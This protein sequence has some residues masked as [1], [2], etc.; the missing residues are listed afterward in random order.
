MSHP[1]GVLLITSD[2]DA[3]DGVRAVLASGDR[4]ELA[5]VCQALSE[6]EDHFQRSP[7]AAVLVDIDPD[8]N[9]VLARLAAL[10][11]RFPDTRFIVL[12]DTLRSDVLMEAMQAGARHFLV[13]ASIGAELAGAL[14]RLVPRG[15]AGPVGHGTIITVLSASGGCGATT[16][17]VNLANELGL[18]TSTTAL[19]VDLDVC[20]GA[21]A[22]YL[23]LRGQF[24]I[25]DVF[26]YDGHIDAH[27]IQTTSV[28]YS[29]TL[30][31]LL[32]P[33]AVS[34]S[35]P[36]PLRLEALADG[37]EAC[38][39]AFQ[40]TVIDAPRV[41][42]DV[43]AELARASKLT[44]IVFELIVT[45]IHLARSCTAALV[46]RGIPRERILPVANRYARR[47]PV[48]IKEAREAL[49]DTEVALVRG[50]FRSAVQSINYGQPLAQIVPR[51][52]V[53][54]DIRALAT[55]VVLKDEVA[56]GTRRE[57]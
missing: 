52:V 34:F 43:A 26:A 57:R 1:D 17:A 41:P 5:G 3:I 20:Y 4:F 36:K 31:V 8:A 12:A 35:Q 21:A 38:R 51:S 25:A 44:L 9:G 16:V 19:L 39:S 22:S 37:L 50:D 32:S 28:E 7:L 6:A 46:E 2:V 33:A 54:K 49:G 47:S 13:K 18:E 48:G 24:G 14:D 11:G 42:M 15:Y 55:D 45:D 40:H 10:T 56:S 29:D 30:R 27:L 53:R 23:G